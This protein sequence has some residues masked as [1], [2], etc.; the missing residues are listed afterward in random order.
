MAFV[1]GMLLLLMEEE[2]AFWT[3]ECI[4][5]D[6]LPNYYDSYLGGLQVTDCRIYLC[7]FYI[8]F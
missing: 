5:N 1:T 8:S 7:L 3:L 6:V 4:V 2:D